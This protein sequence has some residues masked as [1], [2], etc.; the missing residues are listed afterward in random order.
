MKLDNAIKLGEICQR[1]KSQ[2]KTYLDNYV[3]SAI[4]L[5]SIVKYIEN[6][7]NNADYLN[8]NNL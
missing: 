5:I 2:V 3:E 1:I 6:T 8:S 4:S 7:I